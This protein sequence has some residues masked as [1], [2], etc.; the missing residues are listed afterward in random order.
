M[1]ISAGWRLCRSHKPSLGG[2]VTEVAED[3]PYFDVRQS[4]RGRNRTR[5]IIAP[6]FAVGLIW[7]GMRLLSEDKIQSLDID[8]VEAWT[9]WSFFGAIMIG[10][11]IYRLLKELIFALRARSTTGEWHFRLTDRDLLWQVPDHAHG[12]EEGFAAPLTEIER[13][14]FKT[15]QKQEDMDVRQYWVHFH[16]RD[17]I[18][19][20]S[21]SGVSLSWVV[22]KIRAVG[23]PYEETF[24]NY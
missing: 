14:E 11:G 16:A 24:E 19:L 18:Q 7:F 12:K 2:R 6:V 10:T 21:F 1:R 5:L 9:V 13:I 17:P 22:D 20:R 23:V 15:I 8:A 4:V 3:E